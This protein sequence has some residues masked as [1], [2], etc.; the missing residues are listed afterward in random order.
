MKAT[1]Q[2]ILTAKLFFN[3]AFP[4]MKVVLKDNP[5]VAKAWANVNAIVQFIGRDD[6][7]DLACYLEFKDGDL[8][9]KQGLCETKPDLTLTF[10]T[11]SKM[12]KMFKG[13]KTALP[14]FSS[15]GKGLV[16]KPK[17]LLN[18]IMLLL[19]LMLMMPTVDPTDELKKYLKVK[20]SLYMITTALSVANKLGWEN[21]TAWTNQPDRIYQFTVGD[22]S[23]PDIAC[24]LR[25]KGGN[26]KA[27]RGVYERKSPFVNFHFFSIDGALN[28]LLKKRD[29][30]SS[31]SHGDVEIIGA[32]EYAAQLNDLMAILQDVLTTL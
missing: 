22:M 8:E 28:V 18:T 19:Q 6:D 32:P 30:V 27:G 31:V 29:F 3:A 12:V 2:E 4:V 14:D 24:Y 21:M 9:V 13:S 11:V 1:A 23:N 26:T 17:L 7:G 25:V 16:T 15:I 10:N 5:K 20:M